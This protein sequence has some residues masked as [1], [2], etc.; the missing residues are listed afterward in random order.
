MKKM[1][2]LW[3][4]FPVVHG[5]FGRMW[6]A[7]GLMIW[8]MFGLDNSVHAQ[9]RTVLFS[10]TDPGISKPANWGLDTAWYDENN[11]RRGGIFMGTNNVDIV[12]ISFTTTN[13][14]V[15]GQL[16]AAQLNIFTNRLTWVDRW[17]NP[18]TTVCIN[19]DSPTIDP[20]YYDG[21]VVNATNWAANIVAHA[22]R[23]KE[24]G[25]TVV[26]VSPFNE[27]DLYRAERQASQQKFYD[28]AGFLVTNSLIVTNN[29]RISGGNT[30]NTDGANSWYNFLKPRL[31]EGNTH[32]LAGSFDNFASFFQNVAASGDHATDDEMHNVMEAMVGVE[33][34]LNTGIWWGT[35]E[36]ARGEFVKA[37]DGKRLAYAEHRA[38]WTAA[39]VY[40]GTNGAVQAF[41]GESERQA[42]PTT[43][44]FFSKDRDVFYDSDGPRRDYTVATTGDGTYGSAAHRSAEKVVNITWGAD[45]PPLINGRYLIVNR[46]SGKVLQVPNSSLANGVQL[47]QSTYTNGIN[48]QWDVNPLP[49]TFG[50]DYS[51]Y[52]IKAAHSGV[53]VDVQGG[54]YANGATIQQ[55]D[56]GTNVFEQWILQYTTNG[57]FKIRTRW[58]NKV[59]GVNGASTANGA[60]IVQ[61][62]DNGTTDHEWRFIPTNAAVE[63]IAPAVPALV[64][65][66]ASAV[67]VQLNW[68][69]NSE[70]DLA[71]Y[72]VL[73]STNSGGPYDIVA[74]GLTNNAFTDK[75]A[76]QPRTYFYVVK[77]ADKSL[78]TSANSAQVSA[79]PTIIPALIARY[80]FDGNTNDSSGNANH[81][82][83]TYGTPAF[84]AGKY[85]PA[86]SLDGASQ[87]TMLPAGMFASVTNFTIAAWV[88]WNGGAA[89]QRV[90]DF[91]NDTTQ[92]MFLS[93]SS[94]NGTLRFAVTTN[95]GGGEQILETSPLT[96]GQWRHVAITRNGNTAR[97]YTNGI[98][99]ATNTVTIAP[100]SFNPALN[101]LGASQ[102]P[103]PL[104][105]GRLDE[106]VVYNYALSATEIMRLLNNQLPVFNPS[107]LTVAAVGNTLNLA[108]P[109]DHTGWRL[110]TQTNGLA[111]NWFDIAAATATNAIALPKNSNLG[112]VFYRLVYP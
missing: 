92:Y 15:A 19:E 60:L 14:L 81:P 51:Y 8:M 89:W 82:I 50:G 108:W 91:G 17:A 61:W 48:Q 2:C 32:Q 35:A 111:G 99:A 66:T 6:C 20:W 71:S 77:A 26:A 29:I 97:L 25:R 65:A 93:P 106:M 58:C 105:N 5:S 98:L 76:N 38:N 49:N 52:T 100:A 90:F 79:T 72:T 13:A 88:Y 64:T 84:V 87:Y 74:R 23:A 22:K 85:G 43:Y 104:F 41:I 30:L 57:W 28:T 83:L 70:S 1:T 68:K 34:G 21:S 112:S 7:F 4:V 94:G 80:P 40:R 10:P 56:G 39:S 42:L 63:F 102:Y 75:S 16:G 37:S 86:M 45:V 103:D 62:D 96:V 47:T 33:Y 110:Q 59:M 109:A 31:D 3:R 73:R 11:V 101:F 12:R 54:S 107:N 9:D 95:G 36:R 46:N 55:W 53:T 44:R 18:S 67:S 27:P 69:T 78:N 24:W